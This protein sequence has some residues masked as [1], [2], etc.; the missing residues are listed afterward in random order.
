MFKHF[1]HYHNAKS[2]IYTPDSKD[3]VIA[4]LGNS[5]EV[6]KTQCLAGTAR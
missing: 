4:A 6:K 5:N 1:L 2:L 3:V